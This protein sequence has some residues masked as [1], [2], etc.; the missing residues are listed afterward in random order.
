MLKGFVSWAVMMCSLSGDAY[1]VWLEVDF[2]TSGTVDVA[3]IPRKFTTIYGSNDH[4]DASSGGRA[5][6][7]SNDLYFAKYINQGILRFPASRC[8]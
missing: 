1:L 7:V 3:A 8:S 4:R 6:T 5:H 2:I